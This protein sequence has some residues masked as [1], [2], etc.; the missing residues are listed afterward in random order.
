MRPSTASA[1]AIGNLIIRPIRREKLRSVQTISTRRRARRNPARTRGE[2]PNVRGGREGEEIEG[3]EGFDASGQGRA[4]DSR[5]GRLQL[6]DTVDGLINRL[7]R[8]PWSIWFVSAWETRTR[9]SPRR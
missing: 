5:R 9:T 6:V 2:G 3:F 4:G 8:F 7:G 1:G